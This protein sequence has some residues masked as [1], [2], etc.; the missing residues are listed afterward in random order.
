MN[1]FHGFRLGGV[2]YYS[3][4]PS[5]L[6]TAPVRDLVGYR[7]WVVPGPR[8]RVGGSPGLPFC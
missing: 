1:P 4:V 5:Q 2:C 7:I 8:G 6:S 3:L